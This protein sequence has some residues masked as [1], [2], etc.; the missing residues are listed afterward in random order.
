MSFIKHIGFPSI[1]CIVSRVLIPAFL[2]LGSTTARSDDEPPAVS[3]PTKDNKK[4]KKKKK[5]PSNKGT[6]T[7]DASKSPEAP[8]TS[9][10]IRASKLFGGELLVTPLSDFFFQYGTRAFYQAGDHVQFGVLYLG[11]SADLK[12][13]YTPSASVTVSNLRGTSMALWGYGRFFVG[14]SFSVTSG[15]GYRSASITL[16]IAD[17]RGLGLSGTVSA[18]SFVIPV[19][20]GNHWSWE[21]G[22]TIGC[23]WISVMIPITSASSSTTSTNL[24]QSTLTTF[25]EFMDEQ[26]VKISKTISGTLGLVSIGHLF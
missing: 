23:D 11:G 3:T 6:E 7:D 17:N 4:K 15:L 14:N 20:I 1:M 9:S 22:L 13:K 12:D 24:G 26:A 21:N 8:P 18:T 10:S 2:V 25:S 16:D 19:A 5:T